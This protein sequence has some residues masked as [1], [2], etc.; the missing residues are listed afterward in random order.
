MRAATDELTC[1]TV[2]WKCNFCFDIL[3]T[4]IG[5][6]DKTSMLDLIN[7]KIELDLSKMK[8]HQITVL[9]PLILQFQT[10]EKSS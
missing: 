3:K 5:S 9:L 4:D 8:V 6:M 7:F 10:L 1:S 2:M